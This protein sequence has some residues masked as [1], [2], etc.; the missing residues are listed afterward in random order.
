M[1]YSE[2]FKSIQGEGKYTGYP[3]VWLR[4]FLC[5]LN[6]DGFGQDDPTDKSTYELPYEKI[7]VSDITDLSNM[8]VFSKGCDSSYSWAKKFKHLQHE[9]SPENVTKKL[10]ELLPTCGWRSDS[11]EFHMVF[12]G[13]EPLLK[14]NQKNVVDLLIAWQRNRLEEQPDF[15][16]FETNGTQELTDELCVEFARYMPREVLLSYSPK[17]FTVSG[18]ENKKAIKPDVI[19]NNEEKLLQHGIRHDETFKF[20]LSPSP[21]A[22]DEL[23][24]VVDELNIDRS[25]VWIMPVGGVVEDQ[26]KHAGDVADMAIDKGYKVSARVHAYLWGNAL[27]K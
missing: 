13:G 9:D 5:N 15:F 4:M 6:C 18:E 12:T 16:T 21:Q 1:L 17:L 3:S 24:R 27:G 22:W 2:I 26:I 19:R 10:N 23:E 25:K 8:P 7:D 11:S 14:P 20:V